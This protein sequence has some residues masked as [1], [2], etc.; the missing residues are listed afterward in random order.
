M[1]FRRGKLISCRTLLT[2]ESNGKNINAKDFEV[3][4]N[5]EKA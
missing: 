1:G 4:A 3:S 2:V 5:A